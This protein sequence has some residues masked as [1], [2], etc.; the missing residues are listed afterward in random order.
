MS[1]KV[2]PM[3]CKRTVLSLMNKEVDSA[4]NPGR[5]IIGNQFRFFMIQ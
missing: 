1:A 2:S 4:K 3:I 5:R